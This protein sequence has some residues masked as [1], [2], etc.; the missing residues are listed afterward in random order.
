M[1]LNQEINTKGVV[2]TGGGRQFRA[3]IGRDS[4]PG[5]GCAKKVHYCLVEGYHV[6]DKIFNCAELWGGR[7]L[8]H[9]YQ[10]TL[11][12]VENNG[13]FAF[14]AWW[15]D[16]T[17]EADTKRGVATTVTSSNV[18]AVRATLYPA[19]DLT[20][21]SPLCVLSLPRPSSPRPA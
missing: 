16:Y 20:R 11:G 6:A 15:E 7:C 10:V 19:I 3:H 13:P 5:R 21:W 18:A 14:N 4:C 17:R 1:V 2:A 9:V 8:E 12:K